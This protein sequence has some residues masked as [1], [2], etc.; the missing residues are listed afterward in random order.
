MNSILSAV[1]LFA[2]LMS[3]SQIRFSKLYDINN[4]ADAGSN[5]LE[6]DSF[7]IISG[8]NG[9][10]D[11]STDFILV[12]ALKNG[13]LKYKN[14]YS[15]GKKIIVQSGRTILLKNGNLADYRTLQEYDSGAQNYR[16]WSV[17]T[18]FNEK[19]DKLWSK[20][21]KDPKIFWLAAQTIVETPDSG[22]VLVAD[23]EVTLTNS[24]PVLI[25][26]DKNGN[27]LFRK[28]IKTNKVEK[29][30]SVSLYPTGGFVFFGGGVSPT[31]QLI[32]VL[33]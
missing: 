32:L 1:F 5:V 27:E 3:Y 19:G 29:I 20:Q 11:G 4:S 14:S 25:R 26:T 10:S 2:S 17:L 15:Y 6:T 7:Y 21:Y 8:A 22:F 16:T 28:E 33:G 13:D 12:S 18:V 30:F 23:K 24:N 9:K 31:A